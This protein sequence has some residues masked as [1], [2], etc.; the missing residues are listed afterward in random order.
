MDDCESDECPR[1]VRRLAGGGVKRYA[2]FVACSQEGVRVHGE[3]ETAK[4]ASAGWDSEMMK[5]FP[6]ASIAP[7]LNNASL[8]LACA[9]RAG[10]IGASTGEAEQLEALMGDDAW[11]DVVLCGVGPGGLA[12]VLGADDPLLAAEASAAAPCA[13]PCKPAKHL[14]M[15]QHLRLR[16]VPFG[17]D[18]RAAIG[19]VVLALRRA[20]KLFRFLDAQVVDVAIRRAQPGS[21]AEGVSAKRSMLAVQLAYPISQRYTVVEENETPRIISKK[22]GLP[23]LDILHA[24]QHLC[25]GSE[26]QS[27]SK[28]RKGT[29]IT[30]PP[31]PESPDT[32]AGGLSLKNRSHWDLEYLVQYLHGSNACG[33]REWL[34]PELIFQTR[35]S[36]IV[37]P[38]PAS[39]VAQ[40]ASPAPTKA[41]LL[42]SMLEGMSMDRW[43]LPK[44][45]DSANGYESAARS[46]KKLDPSH[47]QDHA[48]EASR[49][50]GG[51]MDAETRSK[52]SRYVVVG[53]SG[54]Q[55]DEAHRRQLLPLMLGDVHAS[56]P[57]HDST[58]GAP[59]GGRQGNGRFTFRYHAAP[60]S[61]DGGP[62]WWSPLLDNLIPPEA[63]STMKAEASAGS[64]DRGGRDREDA[65]G[66]M[67]LSEGR[68]G[69]GGVDKRRAS[70]V[71][72]WFAG[73]P[74][75]WESLD[76]QATILVHAFGTGNYRNIRLS[77]HLFRSTVLLRSNDLGLRV[78]VMKKTETTGA[79]VAAGQQ[80][81]AAEMLALSE[82]VGAAQN[83]N[84]RP[85]S[86]TLIDHLNDLPIR[87]APADFLESLPKIRPLDANGMPIEASIQQSGAGET[88]RKHRKPAGSRPSTTG[89]AGGDEE[90]GVAR[91][92]ETRKRPERHIRELCRARHVNYKEDELEDARRQRERYISTCAHK[93][94]VQAVLAHRMYLLFCKHAH[95][96]REKRKRQDESDS[97]SDDPAVAARIRRAVLPKPSVLTMG[98]P[99]PFVTPAAAAAINL[100]NALHPSA[101]Q[102]HFRAQVERDRWKRQVATG[103]LDQVRVLVAQLESNVLPSLWAFSYQ[104]QVRARLLTVLAE[105]TGAGVCQVL[106][107]IAHNLCPSIFKFLTPS[108]KPQRPKIPSVP[109]VE[110]ASSSGGAGHALTAKVGR[111]TLSGS[112]FAAKRAV[113]Q[114]SAERGLICTHD[115]L[116]AAAV[117]AGVSKGDM[118]RAIQN[119]KVLSNS[120]WR[121]SHGGGGSGGNLK[122]RMNLGRTGGRTLIDKKRDRRG[123]GGIRRAMPKELDS[124]EVREKRLRSLASYN[125]FQVLV[126]VQTS[127]F[128]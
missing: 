95:S 128:T 1:G 82:F 10:S 55:N 38:A 8:G 21:E 96:F 103:S 90:W 17:H 52:T 60:G 49:A 86:D 70:K 97:E 24:N 116:T 72:L 125:R 81:P 4:L 93:S 65:V 62:R 66:N 118:H 54:F 23:L 91:E 42:A 34:R 84:K 106:A 100:C 43:R 126:G 39:G 73:A 123:V 50:E 46:L 33:A 59:G 115:S 67:K 74:A 94:C 102:P 27:H 29:E 36:R 48:M 110:A 7:V 58:R 30:L 41:Q 13:G 64:I 92:E 78:L 68:G 40:A 14:V 16:A 83:A 112:T 18:R 120:Q 61:S 57:S 12:M 45:K 77:G 3:Y 107:I 88:R 111:D 80:F 108:A 31:F 71:G 2:V 76:D 25:E 32:E 98:M 37:V 109:G 26:I 113:D 117:S 119:G 122:A 22:F 75:M 89:G 121:Y 99:T 15:P 124:A 105:A 79:T 85:R 101:F 44:V 87:D 47:T 35:S 127:V 69:E 51:I 114:W 5:R 104:S 6:L 20:P 19:D 63:S 11:H 53:G 9:Q 28:L 56:V